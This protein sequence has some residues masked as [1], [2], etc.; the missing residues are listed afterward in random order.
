MRLQHRH[1]ATARWQKERKHIPQTATA[2]GMLKKKCARSSREQKKNTG[3]VFLSSV[4][5]RSM[6]FAA[7]LG[8]NTDQKVHQEAAASANTSVP[9][10][11]K[12]K[13]QETGQSV[14]CSE[15]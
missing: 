15:L 7:V 9:K 4:I 2:E 1:S 12:I 11:S 14:P 3:R 10:P 5:K 8:G 6:S 13:Q